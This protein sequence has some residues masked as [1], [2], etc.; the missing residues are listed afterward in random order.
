MNQ[1][2][3]EIYSQQIIEIFDNIFNEEE[4]QNVID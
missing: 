1:N 4:L 2:I 3:T